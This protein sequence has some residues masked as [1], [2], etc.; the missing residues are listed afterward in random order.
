M[1]ILFSVGELERDVNATTKIVIQLAEK[2]CLLGHSCAVAGVCNAFPQNEVVNGVQLVR[3]PSVSP[4]VKASESFERFFTSEGRNRNSSRMEFVKRHP[5]HGVSLFFKYRPE[6]YKNVEQPR[7][8]KQIKAFA[9]EFKP[10]ALV[11]VCKPV[12]PVE[13]VALSDISCPVYFYQ[14][15]P[16]GLHRI[17]NPQNSEDIINRELAVF[18]KAAHIFTTP[19]LMRQY[20]QH[21]DYSRYLYKAEGVEFPNIREY[22]PQQ[23]VKSA[24]DFDSE[25]VN[26]LFCGILTD[27]FRSPEYALKVIAQLIDKGEKI[28]VYFMGVNNSRVLDEYMERYPQ[29]IFFRDRVPAQV[30][31][32]TME[33]ADVL[34]NISNTLDNQVPSKIFDY[35]S[36]GKA[37]LNLQKIENCP[38]REYFDRYPLSFTLEE[39]TAADTEQLA[40]FLG[41]S[42]TA[43]L[44]FD[45]VKEI[46]ADATVDY[47]AQC[48]EKAFA[49]NAGKA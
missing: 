44:D 19:V 49:E 38:A 10:D 25:Y 48:M 11:C 42:K 43:H 12:L 39:N 29:N 31:F 15:D 21:K 46:F 36:M 40:A 24:I 3:L 14:V 32:A 13:T 4:I 35:F 9:S 30:A 17:D 8:L 16:W 2:L 27:E 23:G 26:I 34:F 28:R 37:V 1:K 47:V 20:A 18:E 33:K 5:L 41:S 22:I 45:K 6:Y 7:Y